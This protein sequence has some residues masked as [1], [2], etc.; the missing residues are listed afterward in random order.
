MQTTPAT[1]HTAPDFVMGSVHAT[2]SNTIG[3]PHLVE[4]FRAVPAAAEACRYREEVLE[5]NVLGRATVAGRHTTFRQLKAL[6]RLDPAYREF[7]VLRQLWDVDPD[8]QPLLAGVLV[9]AQDEFFRVSF[10]ALR[11][12]RPGEEV[13]SADLAGA[14]ATSPAASNLSDDTVAKTGRNTAASW[15]Q[16]GHLTGRTKK[17][18]CA[19]DPAPVAVAY[20]AYLGDLAG[21]RGLLTLRTPWAALLDLTSGSEVDAL[22]SAHRL[23]ILDLRAGGGVV[24][25]SFPRLG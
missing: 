4:L 11:D 2:A 17:T 23:G 21:N 20:A 16:T 13:T 15:T 5:N 25:M 24:E 6:Y 7:A 19:I 9:A 18:R 14:I 10:R 1:T 8:A 22:R 3:V 12:L